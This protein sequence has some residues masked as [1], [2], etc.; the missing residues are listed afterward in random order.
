MKISVGPVGAVRPDWGLRDGSLVSFVGNDG[1]GH[2]EVLAA[3]TLCG[4]AMA[5]LVVVVLLPGARNEDSVWQAVVTLLGNGD[6]RSAGQAL[7]L[8]S[9]Q[10]HSFK[11]GWDSVRC[12]H[13]VYAPGLSALELRR[14][15]ELN[16]SAPIVVGCTEF[17]VTSAIGPVEVVRIGG[18]A[19]VIDSEGF[20]VPVV[21]DPSGPI[22]RPA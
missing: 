18:D 14:L 19:L 10:V 22:Y 16:P 21:Y 6:A 13:F 5:G 2:P 4:A 9:L 15:R 7:S 12:A 3:Q 8:L 11:T 1:D 17:D 20:E